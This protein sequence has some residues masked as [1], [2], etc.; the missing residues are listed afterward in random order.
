MHGCYDR[1]WSGAAYCSTPNRGTSY[2]ICTMH[3]PIDSE[4]AAFNRIV[5]Y[6]PAVCCC[7]FGPHAVS[8]FGDMHTRSVHTVRCSVRIRKL[9]CIANVAAMVVKAVTANGIHNH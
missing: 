2:H 6:V 1:R 8:L 4:Y 9:R 7:C 3:S 5:P